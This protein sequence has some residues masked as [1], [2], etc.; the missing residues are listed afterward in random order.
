MTVGADKSHVVSVIVGRV[1]ILVIKFKWDRA[2]SPCIELADFAAM[3]S[4]LDEPPFASSR[5]G[6][7]FVGAGLI[8]S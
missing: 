7:L 3:S 8:P 4:F 6:D 1:S 5:A 2:A